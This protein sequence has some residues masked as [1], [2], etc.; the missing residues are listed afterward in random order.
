MKK[1]LLVSALAFS[2]SGCGTLNNGSFDLD[3]FYKQVQVYVVGACKF[4]PSILSIASVIASLFPG[5]APIAGGVK[6]AGDAICSS[7]GTSASAAFAQARS[8][9]K[10]LTTIVKTPRGNVVVTGKAK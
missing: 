4:E 6:L 9:G 10:P 1:L 2:L 5:G 8:A 3:A 7:F